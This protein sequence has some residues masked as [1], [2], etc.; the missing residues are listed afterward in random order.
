MI[1]NLFPINPE[2]PVTVLA[3]SL[4]SEEGDLYYPDLLV[5]HIWHYYGMV[6]KGSARKSLSDMQGCRS[7]LSFLGLTLSLHSRIGDNV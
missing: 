7:F 6:Y 2:I 3:G 1:F 4:S 5:I